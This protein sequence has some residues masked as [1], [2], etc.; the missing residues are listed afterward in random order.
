MLDA[1]NVFSALALNKAVCKQN[2]FTEHSQMKIRENLENP[3]FFRSESLKNA[4]RQ[5]FLSNLSTSIR[6]EISV[7]PFFRNILF[8]PA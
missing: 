7:Q 2:Y 6:R 8:S 1:E 3:F 4:S 5:L